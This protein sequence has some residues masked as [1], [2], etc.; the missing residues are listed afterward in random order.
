MNVSRTAPAP[1][2]AEPAMDAAESQRLAPN[3]AKWDSRAVGYSRHPDRSDYINQL[4]SLLDVAPGQSLFDMG[5]GPG[6]LS[7]PLAQ[8]GI[9]VWAADFS[10]RM[11]EE[12]ALKAREAHL[13]IPTFQRAWQEDWSDIP[14]ADVAISSRSFIVDDMREGIAKLESKARSRAVITTVAGDSPYTDTRFCE[15]A[16]GLAHD[17]APD[18]SFANLLNCLLSTGRRP[19]VDYICYPRA[20]RFESVGAALDHYLELAERVLGEGRDVPTA[21]ISAWVEAHAVRR[22]DCPSC[23]RQDACGKDRM[24][25]KGT[26]V[27]M[28]YEKQICWGYLEWTP[29]EASPSSS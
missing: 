14:V 23:E 6:V 15:E 13:S 12:F 20:S 8:A 9:T 4:V 10:P 19:R 22:H 21:A 2:V 26:E 29:L 27:E 17:P 7:I 1:H 16:L 18:A 25:R 28:D 11:L 3:R 24:A 5:C